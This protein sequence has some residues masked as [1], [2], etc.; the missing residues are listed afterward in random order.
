M[1]LLLLSLLYYKLLQNLHLLNCVSFIFLILLIFDKQLSRCSREWSQKY[2]TKA[3]RIWQSVTIHDRH[4]SSINIILPKF[5]QQKQQRH[6]LHQWK[7]Y[8]TLQCKKKKYLLLWNKKSKMS[9]QYYGFT[10]WKQTTLELRAIQRAVCYW[11]RRGLYTT[12]QTWKTYH[13][14]LSQKGKRISKLFTSLEKKW[15]RKQQRLVSIIK[16][17]TSVPQKCSLVIIVRI[18]FY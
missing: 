16:K 12:F 17:R 5:Q 7:T 9:K 4:L 6:V 14:L 18:V 10:R 3:L 2:Q 11:Q 13:A 1:K 15:K 8:S